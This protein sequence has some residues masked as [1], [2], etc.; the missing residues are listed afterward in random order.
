MKIQIRPRLPKIFLGLLFMSFSVFTAAA[1]IWRSGPKSETPNTMQPKAAG[2]RAQ[3]DTQPRPGIIGSFGAYAVW[4]TLREPFRKM[5][6]R[7]EEPNAEQ[8]I[9]TGLLSRLKSK[10]TDPIPVRV[11]LGRANQLRIEEGNKATIYDGSRLTRGSETLTEDDA[12]E[13]ETLLLDSPERLFIGQV[14]GNAMFQLGSRFRTDDGSAPN[15]TGP[16]YDIYDMAEGLN[17]SAKSP[18]ENI[19]AL[20]TKRYY[21]NSYTSLIERIIYIRRREGRVQNVEIN[22]GDYR[23]VGNQQSPFS[24]IRIEDGSPALEFKVN[25]ATLVKRTQ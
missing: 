19:K 6:A 15:Y 25:S 7:L 10:Q 20:T 24:I 1:M 12:D 4:P 13:A 3:R 16:Y 11:I 23:A 2:I 9:F 22:L 14:S 21:I 17:I 18:S 5:A 8:I